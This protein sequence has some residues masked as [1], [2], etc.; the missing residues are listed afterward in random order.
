MDGATIES[1]TESINV[2]S[3]CITSNIDTIKSHAKNNNQEAVNYLIDRINGHAMFIKAM[4]Q[5][6]EVLQNSGSS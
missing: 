2:A 6:I 1:I 4:C 3:I 5:K